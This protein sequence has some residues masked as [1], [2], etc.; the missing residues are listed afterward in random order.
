MSGL[1]LGSNTFTDVPKAVVPNVRSRPKSG[2]REG[3]MNKSMI[4]KKKFKICVTFK[5][6]D[7][8]KLCEVSTCPVH[9]KFKG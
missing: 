2:S 9:Y 1:R 5:Q 3:F 6:N 8:E 4:T 7:Q